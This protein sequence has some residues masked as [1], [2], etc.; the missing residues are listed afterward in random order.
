[1]FDDLFIYN[2]V[3]SNIVYG[4]YATKF[5]VNKLQGMLPI[6][7]WPKMLTVI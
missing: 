3:N 1:V 2:T 5:I 7:I 4:S 6:Y